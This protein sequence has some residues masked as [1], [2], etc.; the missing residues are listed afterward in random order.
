MPCTHAPRGALTG[1]IQLPY[2]LP[3]LLNEQTACPLQPAWL[4]PPFVEPVL[5]QDLQARAF[6][7]QCMSPFTNAL[8]PPNH[9]H[10]LPAS[11]L[12]LVS[13][14]QHRRLSRRQC[15][16]RQWRPG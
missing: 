13:L 2:G 3:G 16:L 14:G 5:Q 6:D 1:Y 10:L 12:T 7:V 15:S 8:Q 9:V 11:I 4:P